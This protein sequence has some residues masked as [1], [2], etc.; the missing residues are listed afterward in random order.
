MN[1]RKLH[2]QEQREAE[3]LDW[4]NGIRQRNQ[5]VNDRFHAEMERLDQ[6]YAARMKKNDRDARLMFWAIIGLAVSSFLIPAIVF[7]VKIW[8]Q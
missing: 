1:L 8:T 3:V 2:Q 5:A 6:E 4:M 7:A